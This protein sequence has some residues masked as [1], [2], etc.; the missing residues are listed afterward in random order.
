MRVASPTEEPAAFEPVEDGGDG[1][2]P[3]HSDPLGELTGGHRPVLVE[4]AEAA[5]VGDVDP[6]ARGEGG[7]EEHGVGG[8]P[9]LL[10]VERGDEPV[11]GGS[12]WHSGTSDT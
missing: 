8:G 2:A 9:P 7:V 1:A 6:G 12:S 11:P 3:G 4:H 10:V 5:H